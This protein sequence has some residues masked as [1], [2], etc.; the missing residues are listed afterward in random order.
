MPWPVLSGEYHDVTVDNVYQFYQHLRHACRDDDQYIV[1]MQQEFERWSK[2]NLA[3]R[4][5]D[6]IF[7]GVYR[8]SLATILKVVQDNLSDLVDPPVF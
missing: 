3:E 6:S 2:N 4:L 1:S 7:R 8:R 5:S